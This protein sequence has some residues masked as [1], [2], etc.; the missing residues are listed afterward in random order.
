MC[1]HKG[2]SWRWSGV[3]RAAVPD[4]GESGAAGP[5]PGERGAAVPGTGMGGASALD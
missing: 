1:T 3:R 4:M 2:Y 5:G